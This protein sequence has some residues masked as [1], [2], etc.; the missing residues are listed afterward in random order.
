[1]KSLCV[2]CRGMTDKFQRNTLLLKVK[3]ILKRV[4]QFSIFW[5]VQLALG[6]AGKCKKKNFLAA[7][8]PRKP[9]LIFFLDLKFYLIWLAETTKFY[10]IS[11]SLTKIVYSVSVSP[12][13]KFYSVSV[14]PTSKFYSTLGTPT[15]VNEY[16]LPAMPRPLEQLSGTHNGVKFGSW[17]HQNGVKFCRPGRQNVVYIGC[18]DTRTK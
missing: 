14:S 1:M 8:I 5:P 13:S 10:S 6:L 4:P 2:D 17:G 7:N 18:W 9:Y 12:T 16:I 3:I 11:V 15:S